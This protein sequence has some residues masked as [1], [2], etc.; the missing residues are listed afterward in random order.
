VVISVAD[1]SDWHFYVKKLFTPKTLCTRKCFFTPK[2]FYTPN[3]F[4]AKM[5]K[6]LTL[7]VKRP[8]FTNVFTKTSI[9]DQSWSNFDQNL[10]FYPTG[11]YNMDHIWPQPKSIVQKN[12]FDFLHNVF[13]LITSQMREAIYFCFKLIVAIFY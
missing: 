10:N 8:I 6:I 9:F 2:T 12:N 13:N 4:Y 11:A 5:T 7:V 3:N 1:E